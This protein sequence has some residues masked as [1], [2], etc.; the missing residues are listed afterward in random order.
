MLEH[1]INSLLVVLCLGLIVGSPFYFR[2]WISTKDPSAVLSSQISGQIDRKVSFL[3]GLI[4]LGLFA[5]SFLFS[6]ETPKMPQ[7]LF[8][9]SILSFAFL[10]QTR[11]RSIPNQKAAPLTRTLSFHSLRPSAIKLALCIAGLGLLD[12]GRTYPA[13]LILFLAVPFLQSFYLRAL[14][15]SNEMVDSP[16]K[17]ELSLSFKRIF[18]ID[19]S[20]ASSP[21]ALLSGTHL[22][23]NLRLFES[24]TPDEL[25]AVV[26]HESAHLSAHHGLKRFA[27][28]VFSLFLG[29]FWFVLPVIFLFP[30]HPEYSIFSTLLALFFQFHCLGNLI[31]KQELEADRGAIQKGA[32]KQ[33][34]I[35]ALQKLSGNRF[36][37]EPNSFERLLFGNFHPSAETRVMALN[38]DAS[39][40]NLSDLRLKL[41]YSSAYSLLVVGIVAWSATQLEFHERSP[42]ST[43]PQSA[44]ISR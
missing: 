7:V 5:G 20:L 25:K 32:E 30:E 4:F 37:H 35:S 26:L 11:A 29:L 43:P 34:F 16:L 2:Y 3:T 38:T 44:N 40:E 22:F 31:Y 19:S 10:Y 33:A 42:A 13:A 41:A 12:I 28:G 39:P 9:A 23:L 18:L 6:K 27:Y 1:P 15:P 36:H 21:N 14:Y 17:K 24:L 8:F